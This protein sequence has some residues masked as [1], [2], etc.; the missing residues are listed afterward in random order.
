MRCQHLEICSRATSN[1]ENSRIRI[2]QRRANL[3]YQVLNDSPST[4]IPPV[5]L[6]NLVEDRI[7]MRLHLFWKI[8]DDDVYLDSGGVSIN[9]RAV[10]ASTNA[11]R[12]LKSADGLEPTASLAKLWQPTHE[13]GPPWPL[14]ASVKF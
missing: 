10:G 7:M 3:L 1:V 14:M 2:V 5:R 12:K 6:L 8:S 13:P 11:G 4:Y 9:L